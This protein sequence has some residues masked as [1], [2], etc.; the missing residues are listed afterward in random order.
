[1]SKAKSLSHKCTVGQ[2]AKVRWQLWN[3]EQISK[4]RPLSHAGYA[5]SNCKKSWYT[6]CYRVH[7]RLSPLFNLCPP[8][9]PPPLINVEPN[10]QWYSTKAG[11][12]L[13]GGRG[14][15]RVLH[16]SLAFY[17]VLF[18]GNRKNA[19]SVS[20]ILQLL[21]AIPKRPALLSHYFSCNTIEIKK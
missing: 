5:T 17:S 14:A 15:T 3:F 8:S 19:E 20:S 4:P 2:Q 7:F 21:V 1:M 18:S 6:R 16:C 10:S 13:K 9:P 11:S 12:T